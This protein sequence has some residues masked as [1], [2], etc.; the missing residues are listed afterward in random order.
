MQVRTSSFLR[1]HMK[2]SIHRTSYLHHCCQQA[3][4]VLNHFSLYKCACRRFVHRFILQ[5]MTKLFMSRLSW[6]I[7]IT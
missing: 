5:S 6:I 2:I 1:Q 7:L 3:Y 4:L